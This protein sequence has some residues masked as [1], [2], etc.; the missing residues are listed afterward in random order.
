MREARRLAAE[1]PAV[2]GR[3]RER[4]DG[5]GHGD[6]GGDDTGRALEVRGADDEHE[7]RCDDGDDGLHDAA[8]VLVEIVI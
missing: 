4:A 5:D 2:D 3:D 1:D 8:V 6:I 7:L